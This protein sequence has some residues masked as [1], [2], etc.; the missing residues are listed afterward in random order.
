LKVYLSVPMIANRALPRAQL[1]A[2]AITDCGHTITS[3]WV[4]GPVEG[5]D[6]RAVDVF[7][8]DT[9]ATEGSDVVVA[10]V[11]EPSI[12]VGMEL[13]AAYK[14]RKRIIL[15]AKKGNVTSRM[16]MHMDRK[17]TVEYDEE[18][19]IYPALSRLLR[20]APAEPIYP[21]PRTRPGVKSEI[22]SKGA[23]SPIGPYSQGIDAGAVYCSGQVG[24]DPQTGNLEE[25]V[26]A[27]TRRAL[28]NLGAVLAE[29][30]LSL[31][32]VVKTTVFL[33]DLAE[34][35]LMNE[36]Y[37]KHFSR[38]FPARSTVQVAALPKGARVEID[39]VAVR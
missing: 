36:E 29:S 24:A 31:E 32:S 38:P 35:P 6:R 13:M 26:V 10:D 21:P 16:L 19:E 14:A 5:A 1:M 33:V 18:A 15:V 37:G 23:P 8:R 17:E 7:Q 30:G 25:G 39:A 34:F 11:T 4:L 2:K 22:R 28:A 12:G 20:P 27:Q 3:P 9:L